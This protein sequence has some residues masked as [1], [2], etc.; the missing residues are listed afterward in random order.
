MIIRPITRTITRPLIRPVPTVTNFEDVP[1][2]EGNALTGFY[3]ATNGL[4]WDTDT[5]WLTDSIV[6]NWYG[7]TVSG[8]HVTRL[9]LGHNGGMSGNGFQYLANLTTLERLILNGTGVSGDIATLATLSN[10]TGTGNWE[11]LRVDGT[12]VETYTSTTLPAWDCHLGLDNL[13]LSQ[14]EVDNFLVDLDTA[15]GTGGELHLENTNSAPSATGESAVD[16]LRGK[17][18]TVVVTGGY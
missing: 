8:G 9:E 5:G 6:G 18:W 12:N 1:R 7:V 17:S 15:G 10:L 2:V 13:G 16:S 11:G 3:H 14:T 4:T